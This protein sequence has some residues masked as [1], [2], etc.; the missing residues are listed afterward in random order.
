MIVTVFNSEAAA[1]DGLRALKELHWEG[2]ITVYATAVLAKDP[3]GKVSVK[4]KADEGPIGT[5]LGML[6][7]GMI[8]LLAGPVAVAAGAAA[9][10]A[11]AASV[12]MGGAAVGASVG[13]LTGLIFDLDKSGIDVQFVEDVSRVLGAGKTAL[14][15]DIDES[16]TAPLDTRMGALGGTVHRRLR[17]DVVDDQIARE[18]AAYRAE[19][20][21]LKHDLE[22]AKAEDKAAIQRQIDSVKARMQAKQDEIRTKV[23]NA[24]SEA[25]AKI[26]AMQSQL[27][28]AHARHKA[29][30]EKRIEEVKA[31]HAARKAKLDQANALIMEALT[32]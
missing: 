25:D 8:G 13:G 26:D 24:K 29:K 10:G 3:S 21:Q 31:E 27:K 30:I 17:Y 23:D 14:L 12:A 11:A 28:S 4:Q 20:A 18:A 32:G 5:A 6:T 2:E 9:A 15:A 19:I 16:W 22:V 7:G 1:A